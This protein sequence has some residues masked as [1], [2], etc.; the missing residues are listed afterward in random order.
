MKYWQEQLEFCKELITHAAANDVEDFAVTYDHFGPRTGP[1]KV[2]LT[3]RM[4]KF[5]LDKL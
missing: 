3:V 2:T 4:S 1:L 5:P